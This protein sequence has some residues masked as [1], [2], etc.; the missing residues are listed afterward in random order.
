MWKRG[1]QGNRLNTVNT[2]V[3]KTL[4]FLTLWYHSCSFRVKDL[5]CSQ[6]MNSSL[7]K[8][9]DTVDLVLVNRIVNR[10]EVG[11]PLRELR[12]VFSTRHL[13][14]QQNVI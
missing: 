8:V 14:G 6:Y 11:N 7:A 4:C 9:S 13:Y 5:F 1:L 12:E 3:V 10:K 2:G